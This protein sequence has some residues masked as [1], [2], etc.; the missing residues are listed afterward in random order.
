MCSELHGVHFVVLGEG[1]ASLEPLGEELG[2]VGLDVL[3]ESIIDGALCLLAVL[4]HGLLLVFVEYVSALGLGGLVLEKSI[5]DSIGVDTLEG[6]LSARGDRVHLVDA[7][8]R[9]TVELERTCHKEKSRLELLQEND[10]LAAVTARGE[11]EHATGLD[12]L[13][14]LGGVLFLRANLTLLVLSRV[15]IELFDH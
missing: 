3:E 4:R 7:L 15:P 5:F 10:A 2:L 9:N 13:A 12:A 6:H 1:E 14:E 8:Q 11:D